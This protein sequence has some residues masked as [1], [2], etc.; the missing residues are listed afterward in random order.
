MSLRLRAC[1]D[2]TASAERGRS[3]VGRWDGRRMERANAKGQLWGS[4]RVESKAMESMESAERVEGWSRRG[5]AS[6]RAEL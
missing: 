3:R 1:G 4:L 2:G 6:R 5:S